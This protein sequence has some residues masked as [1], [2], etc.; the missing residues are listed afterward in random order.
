[1]SNDNLKT[2]D[3][4]ETQERLQTYFDKAIKTYK[5]GP[6]DTHTE[7]EIVQHLIETL[8]RRLSKVY[9]NFEVTITQDTDGNPQ[10]LERIKCK[11]YPDGTQEPVDGE[12]YYYFM[13]KT[14]TPTI[15]IEGKS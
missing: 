14:I 11:Y 2:W 8:I 5:S 7:D 13:M 10:R 9:E 1:M 6:A 4:Y 12:D 3:K 15:K